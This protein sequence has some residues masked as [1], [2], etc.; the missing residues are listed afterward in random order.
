MMKNSL[1]LKETVNSRGCARLYKESFT[2]RDFYD[3]IF[4]GYNNI[5]LIKEGNFII[6]CEVRMCG[7]FQQERCRLN[8]VFLLALQLKGRISSF[9]VTKYK[10][11]VI[12]A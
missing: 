3:P 5:K 8:G 7:D 10:T 11:L 1:N 12:C 9:S 2:F 6:G 4:L